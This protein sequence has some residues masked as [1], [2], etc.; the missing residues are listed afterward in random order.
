MYME[1]LARRMCRARQQ[2]K[3]G[4]IRQ[5]GAVA[6]PGA[7]RQC[8]GPLVSE[9]DEEPVTFQPRCGD[10]EVH[11][12]VRSARWV[13]QHRCKRECGGRSSACYGGCRRSWGRWRSRFCSR[14]FRQVAAGYVVYGPSTVLVYTTGTGVH[15]F[16]LDPTIGAFVL[17][18]EQMKMPEQGSYYSVNEANA[19]GWAGG[20]SHVC[21]TGLRVGSLGRGVQFE[22][23]REPGGGFSPDAT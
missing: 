11:Y 3:L 12:C 2:Q 22:V 4:C 14:G 16:T 5:P 13:E 20:V 6:L 23:Y 21:G 9:E 8:C 1:H 18:N 19:A 15:G 7:A 17:S 10:G